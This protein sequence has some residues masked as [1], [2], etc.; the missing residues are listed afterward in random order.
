MNSRKFY[1]LNIEN[2]TKYLSCVCSLHVG[3]LK[4]HV[5]E[6]YLHGVFDGVQQLNNDIGHV[7]EAQLTSLRGTKG[8]SDLQRVEQE[9]LE[10]IRRGAGGD[11]L[12]TRVSYAGP[13]L[14]LS[15][16]TGL[17]SSLVF[18]YTIAN[19]TIMMLKILNIND[20]S[21]KIYILIIK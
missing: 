9:W 7:L 20:V 11:R 8:R 10:E 16:T 3:G 19:K 13:N 2:I 1:K 18:S 14:S 12:V 4:G 21:V 5:G 17:T 6:G 15:F